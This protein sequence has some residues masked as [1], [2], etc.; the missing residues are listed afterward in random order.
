MATVSDTKAPVANIFQRM[1]EVCRAVGYIQKREKKSFQYRPLAY[2][3]VIGALRKPMLD[4]NIMLT[5]TVLQR[6]QTGSRTDLEVCCAIV[7]TDSDERYES[8]QW[9]SGLNQ[10]DKGVGIALTY[11]VK[12]FLRH[13]FMLEVGDDDPDL[14]QSETHSEVEPGAPEFTEC[15]DSDAPH[16]DDADFPGPFNPSEQKMK[17]DLKAWAKEDGLTTAQMGADIKAHSGGLTFA[18]ANREE[19]LT[20]WSRQWLRREDQKSHE[21]TGDGE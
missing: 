11:A 20:I 21:A 6:I 1:A 18:K 13:N 4:Q 10:Q 8:V 17:A 5:T 19:K 9:G 2:D 15:S 3:D 16:D 12:N 14:H 7:C